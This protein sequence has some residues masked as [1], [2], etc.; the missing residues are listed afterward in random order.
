MQGRFAAVGVALGIGRDD[1]FLARKFGAMIMLQ[2][3]KAAP[4]KRRLS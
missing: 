3:K 2:C 1:L 4:E